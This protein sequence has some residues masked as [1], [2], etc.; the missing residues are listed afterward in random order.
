MAT[1]IPLIEIPV[2][3]YE[4]LLRSERKLIQLEAAGV[5]N[6]VGYD[7]IDWTYVNTGKREAEE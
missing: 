7:E 6:W 4:S 5:D 1:G 3:R 2:Y